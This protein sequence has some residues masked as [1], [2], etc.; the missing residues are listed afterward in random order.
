M[1]ARIAGDFGK[2]YE[3]ILIVDASGTVV[4]D[5]VGGKIK[6]LSLAD[7]AG[8]QAAKQG[9]ANVSPAVKSKVTGNVLAPVAAPVFPMGENLSAQ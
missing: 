1:L 9:T 3:S 2:D 6:G 4:G 5:S 7:R 8:F